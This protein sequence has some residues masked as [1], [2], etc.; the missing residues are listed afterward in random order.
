MLHGITLVR[1][2][3]LAQGLGCSK[4][5]LSTV[6]LR[7]G[8]TRSLPLLPS[9]I[10]LSHAQPNCS[11]CVQPPRP[12]PGP[13]AL[14]SLSGRAPLSLQVYTLPT[15]LCFCFFCLIFAQVFS[16]SIKAL[17]TPFCTLF[18]VGVPQ[19]AHPPVIPEHP[20][21]LHQSVLW[22]RSHP[23]PSHRKIRGDQLP[24]PG[25]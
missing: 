19:F 24:F 17:N 12:P 13:A 2:Q 18:P 16:I 5:C 11:L 8:V 23:T 15:V 4:R 10:A 6:T 3:F 25:R 14:S 9:P 21:R 20:A 7:F 1:V 22:N